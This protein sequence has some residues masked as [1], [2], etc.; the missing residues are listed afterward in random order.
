S[1]IATSVSFFF[2]SSEPSHHTILSGLVSAAISPIHSSRCGL[3]VS[4]LPAES[5]GMLSAVMAWGGQDYRKIRAVA[6]HKVRR[7]PRKRLLLASTSSKMRKMRLAFLTAVLGLALGCSSSTQG[8][9]RPVHAAPPPKDDGKPAEG[10]R[11]GGEHSAA[12][13]QLKIGPAD[14][15]S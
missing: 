14:G 2:S 10:G 3:R 12:L 11:G 7:S 4:G 8:V 1:P 15:R 6:S 5:V 13:E 9:Y